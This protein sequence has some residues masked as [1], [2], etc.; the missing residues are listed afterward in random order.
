M[1]LQ[2]RLDIAIAI[3]TFGGFSLPRSLRGLNAV[4]NGDRE[5]CKGGETGESLLPLAN[6]SSPSQGKV[7]RGDIQS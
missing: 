7:G 1:I 4:A 6:R 2:N 5:D 3:G